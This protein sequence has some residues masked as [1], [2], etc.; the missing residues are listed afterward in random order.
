[1][2]QISFYS[3]KGDDE[4]SAVSCLRLQQRGSQLTRVVV[5]QGV[6]L[7]WRGPGRERKLQTRKRQLPILQ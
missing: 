2:V 7:E 6:T 1:M 4:S 5:L 3:Q